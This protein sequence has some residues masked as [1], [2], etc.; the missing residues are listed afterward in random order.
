MVLSSKG[1][2]KTIDI[3]G[4]DQV[5][6]DSGTPFDSGN[7]SYVI[8]IFG[9]P[10]VTAPWMLQFGGHHLALN[11]VISGERGI[12]TPTMTGAQPAPLQIQ[13]QTIRPLGPESD[14]C[15]TH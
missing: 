1:Y 12:M 9:T 8:G 10:S 13:R 15:L 4:S 6:A 7:D 11:I 2:Q 3:K 14:K 5:L